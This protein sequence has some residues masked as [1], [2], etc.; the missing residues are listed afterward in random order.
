MAMR[1]RPTKRQKCRRSLRGSIYGTPQIPLVAHKA[2]EMGAW[3]KQSWRISRGTLR[4]FRIRC[5]ARSIFFSSVSSSLFLHPQVCHSSACFSYTFPSLKLLA[6]FPL[7]SQVFFIFIATK[8]QAV[9]KIEV[10]RAALFAWTY[11]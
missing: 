10:P 3:P 11:I 4:H 2:V 6:V 9:E 1:P 7:L 5:C 8:T